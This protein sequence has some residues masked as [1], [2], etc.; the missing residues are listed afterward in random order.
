MTVD[1]EALPHEHDDRASS[2]RSVLSG[3]IQAYVTSA[4]AGTDVSLSRDSYST[5]TLVDLAGTAGIVNYS[6]SVFRNDPTCAVQWPYAVGVPTTY[7][8]GMRSGKMHE[9]TDFIPGAGAHI[10]AIADGVVRV[11]TDTGGAFGVTIVIDH[12]IDG[13]TVSSR[14][15]HMEYDSRQVEVGDTVH[16]GQYIGRTGDTG[17]SFGAHLH[18]E[19]LQGGTTATDPLPW[20]R[21]H[22]VC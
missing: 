7:G 15:A 9:G 4:A 10:Q 21:D 2:P 13:Q 5:G 19:V 3:D 17:R 14:Y 16:V 20:L 6:D 22:A 1:A 11:A 12:V 18:F 8:F